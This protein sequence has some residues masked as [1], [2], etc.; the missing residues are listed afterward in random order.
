MPVARSEDAGGAIGRCRRRDRT[1][2]AARSDDAGGAIEGL[3]GDFDG[4]LAR[5]YV[6]SSCARWGIDLI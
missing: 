6:A 5:S 1:M 4:P 3:L 2:P